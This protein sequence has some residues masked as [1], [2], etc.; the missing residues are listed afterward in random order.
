MGRYY[1]KFW[2]H[3]FFLKTKRCGNT[4]SPFPLSNNWIG[5]RIVSTGV[6]ILFAK[7]ASPFTVQEPMGTWGIP[8]T[9]QRAYHEK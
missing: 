7:A 3:D 5:F 8:V 6:S 4:D 9:R 1:I 2:I